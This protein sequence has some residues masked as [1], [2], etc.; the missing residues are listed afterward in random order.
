MSDVAKFWFVNLYLVCNLI[1][2]ILYNC[3]DAVIIKL[4]SMTCYIQ[5]TNGSQK[6]QFY[7]NTCEYVGHRVR[8]IQ[9]I[10]L[11]FK[12]NLHPKSYSKTF[13]HF[14]SPGYDFECPECTRW[15]L[16]SRLFPF[17]L[18]L[19]FNFTHHYNIISLLTAT[20]SAHRSG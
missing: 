4:I 20:F 19:T 5:E 8:L 9:N 11:V 10:L 17:P 14:G 2:Y 15:F 12:T 3:M 6:I 16:N 1:R 18:T 7:S 13:L